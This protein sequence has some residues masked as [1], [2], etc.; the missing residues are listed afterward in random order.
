MNEVE[1]LLV[2]L[3][4]ECAE[5]QKAVSKALRFGLDDG[6]PGENTTNLQ[7]IIKELN[8][9]EGVIQLLATHISF[10]DFGNPVEILKK[11]NKIIEFMDY[12]R[13]RGKLN[14]S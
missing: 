1:H 4:E 12:A 13:K 10:S 14:S 7:D 8:D 2:C 11:K 3:S 5:I 6:Y 9:L